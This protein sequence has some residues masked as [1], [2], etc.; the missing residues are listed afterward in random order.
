MT[1]VKVVDGESVVAVGVVEVAL[2]PL[3]FPSA[4][5]FMILEVV[6]AATA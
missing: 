3:P 5:A 2:A 4:F 6:L 1:A